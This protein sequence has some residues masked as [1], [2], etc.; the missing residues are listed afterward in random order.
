MEVDIQIND[1]YDENALKL[2]FDKYL[3]FIEFWLIN[4]VARDKF[5]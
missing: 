4:M 1:I 5:A 2:S 3:F